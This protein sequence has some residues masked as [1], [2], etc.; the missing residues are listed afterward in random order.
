MEQ[1]GENRYK[2]ADFHL[3][4][5][6]VNIVQALVKPPSQSRSA[7]EI[8]VYERVQ[9]VLMNHGV[10][11]DVDRFACGVLH[12]ELSSDWMSDDSCANSMNYS[13]AFHITA[14]VASELKL[15]DGNL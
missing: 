9:I 3:T 4:L 2:I 15:N 6:V 5:V 10:D 11:Q 1:D 7:D 13:Y 14:S 8:Q 12:Y